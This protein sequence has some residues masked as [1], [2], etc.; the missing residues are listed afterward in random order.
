MH[1]PARLLAQII[2]ERLHMTKNAS[3]KIQPHTVMLQILMCAHYV[4]F[5]AEGERGLWPI[6]IPDLV[7]RLHSRY[8]DFYIPCEHEEFTVSVQIECNDY[9]QMWR[10]DPSKM[11]NCSVEDARLAAIDIEKMLTAGDSCAAFIWVPNYH[12]CQ[13]AVYKQ[14]LIQSPSEVGDFERMLHVGMLRE[15]DL[16]AITAT[17]EMRD[18]GADNEG[19]ENTFDVAMDHGIPDKLKIDVLAGPQR[20][21]WVN[22]KQLAGYQGIK[23]RIK[24]NDCSMA[25]TVTRLQDPVFLRQTVCDLLETN[26]GMQA[27]NRLYQTRIEELE[28]Q[29]EEQRSV[30]PERPVSPEY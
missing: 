14:E 15:I 21:I 6:S 25:H 9:V 2:A 27:Q 13:A 3:I 28:K 26:R 24:F 11:E 29:L 22:P 7:T 8:S 16:S 18:V 5:N 10:G 12:P 1:C 19:L 23:L 4:Q 17:Q 20:S 30:S